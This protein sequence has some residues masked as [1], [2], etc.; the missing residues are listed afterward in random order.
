M[1][2]HAL[3]KERNAFRLVAFCGS[4]CSR[5]GLIA[6]KRSFSMFME[7]SHWKHSAPGVL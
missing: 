4:K 7:L 5:K 1:L 2:K 6:F 3:K